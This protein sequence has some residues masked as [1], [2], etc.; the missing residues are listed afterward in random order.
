MASQ[1]TFSS[2]TKTWLSELNSQRS[3]LQH[4][5][6]S[7][8]SFNPETLITTSEPVRFTLG[9]GT[10]I[11]SSVLSACAATNHELIIVTCFWA[12]SQSQKR[13]ASLLRTLSSKALSQG[14]KI[15]VRICFSSLSLWQK[16]FQTSSL[17]GKIYPP[18]SWPSL[19]LPRQEEMQGLALVVKSIFVRPFSVMHPKFI[20][21]DRK[22]AFLPSCNVSWE[23]WFEGCIEM[24]G[25]IVEKLFDFWKLFWGGVGPAPPSD[26]EVEEPVQALPDS[27]L[28]SQTLFPPIST[29][30]QTILLP[31]PHHQDPHFRP[32]SSWFTPPPTTPLNTFL[33]Q[34]FASAQK[35]IFIQT[36]NLTSRPV[37]S[38]LYCALNRGIDVHIVVSS[39]L[40]LLEQFVTAFT[41]T[42][43]ETWKLQRRYRALWR[44]YMKHRYNPEIGLREPG[45]LRIGYFHKKGGMWE[46]IG[47]KWRKRGI[48]VMKCMDE[49][50][51]SH[52]KTTIVDGEVTVMGSGNMDRASWY[53]SQELGVAFFG[54]EFAGIVKGS[55]D[56]GLEERVKYVC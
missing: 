30:T 18:G 42:E 50:V 33:L 9:S 24:K 52:F 47:G 34:L 17:E 23:V 5:D 8:Y 44:Q 27:A 39:R 54:A 11:L 41:L 53:T 1:L 4:D 13:I 48:D 49:P 45:T 38:A 19:G 21:V 36:P 20:L 31:S 15:R 25:E 40:Q 10:Q 12:R 16:L 51:K 43:Y 2:I 22:T 46:R 32:F 6:P 56:K 35:S 3:S 14:R 26:R 29:P 28:L 7:Y 55:V 37:T